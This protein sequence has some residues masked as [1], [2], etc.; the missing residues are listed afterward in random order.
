[1][2]IDRQDVRDSLET[3]GYVKLIFFFAGSNSGAI[4]AGFL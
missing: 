3:G 4:G 1:V 2:R